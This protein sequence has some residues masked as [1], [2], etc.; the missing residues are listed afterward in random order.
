MDFLNLFL[1][2]LEARIEVTNQSL[3]IMVAK[4]NAHFGQGLKG[5]LK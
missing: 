3:N 4:L 2:S 5:L 1:K